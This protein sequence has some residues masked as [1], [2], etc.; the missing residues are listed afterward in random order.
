MALS[1]ISRGIAA[2]A[3]AAPA[4]GQEVES[5]GGGSVNLYASS[6]NDGM[7]SSLKFSGGKLTK[8]GENA[9]CGPQ[10]TWLTLDKRGNK[11]YCL[12]EGWND[13]LQGA[14]VTSFQTNR[15][16]SLTVLKQIAALK[17]PVSSALYG[18]GKLAV[19]H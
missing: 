18:K 12:D 13:N 1:K 3:F 14:H 15:D 10:P 5:M 19:A 9:G 4:L 7:V 17:S 11:L 6:Y 16:G 2:L 8:T